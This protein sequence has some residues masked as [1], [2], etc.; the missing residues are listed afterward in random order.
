MR[1]LH[2]RSASATHQLNG[3]VTMIGI[4]C[5]VTGMAVESL[6]PQ[7]GNSAIAGFRATALNGENLAP[8]LG[9]TKIA[10][11]P[12]TDMSMENP[13]TQPNHHEGPPITPIPLTGSHLLGRVRRQGH[14]GN[15][16]GLGSIKG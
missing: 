14:H 15:L 11:G 12:A 8:R 9:D 13:V 6:V 2:A 16:R 4:A 10:G 3:H 5:F 1:S 7:L